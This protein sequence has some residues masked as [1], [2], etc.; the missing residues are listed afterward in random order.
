MPIA[1]TNLCF[2]DSL[3][4]LVFSVLALF[5]SYIA[6]MC[7]CVCVYTHKY[8]YAAFLIR[9]IQSFVNIKY[10]AL[11]AKCRRPRGLLMSVVSDERKEAIKSLSYD[12]GAK[13]RVIL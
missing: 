6:F 3:P 9:N 1:F 11:G 12:Y 13:R 8:I 4:H 2:C 10:T 5:V 7:V